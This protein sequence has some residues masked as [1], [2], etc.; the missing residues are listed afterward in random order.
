MGTK[1]KQVKKAKDKPVEVS[2]GKKVKKNKRK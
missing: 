1:K 2:S